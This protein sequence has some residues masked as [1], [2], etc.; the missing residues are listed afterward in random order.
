[1]FCTAIAGTLFTYSHCKT[2]TTLLIGEYHI[3]KPHFLNFI[4]VE[5]L[6]RDHI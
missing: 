4:T 3:L 6:Y 2:F 5:N 1:L